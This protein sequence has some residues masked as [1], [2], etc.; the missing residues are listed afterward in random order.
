MLVLLAAL[1]LIPTFFVPLWHMNF[2]SQQYPDGLDMYIYSHNLVGG[3]DGNDLT[4][5]NVLNHYIGMAELKPED[6]T[7]LKWIPLVI[8]L[9]AVMT[10]RASAIGTIGSVIDTIVMSLYFALYSLWSFWYK[11][12]QYGYNLDSKASVTVDPFTPPVFGHKMVG[13]FE[14]WSYPALGTYFFMIFGLSLLAALYF[15][16]KKKPVA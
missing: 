9:I 3:N 2:W 10:L 16:W 7:E 1:S 15:S 6:F 14:V 12:H 8:G 5:I 11:L 13:Q 4:E